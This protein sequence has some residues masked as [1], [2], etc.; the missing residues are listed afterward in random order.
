[1][2]TEGKMSLFNGKNKKE[3]LIL[4]GHLLFLYPL[5]PALPLQHVELEIDISRSG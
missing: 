1:M 4:R 3:D 2:E 5:F